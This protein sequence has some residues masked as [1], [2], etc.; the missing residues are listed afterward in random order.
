LD[1]SRKNQEFFNQ[2]DDYHS[3]VEELDTYKRTAA[4]LQGEVRG[5]VLDVG[6]GGVF[7]YDTSVADSVVAVDIAEE[8]VQKQDWAPNVSFRWGDATRLPVQDNE[9]DTCVLQLL[10]HHLAEKDYAETERRTRACIAESYRALAPGGRLVILESC[11]PKPVEVVERLTLPLFRRFLDR[12]DHPIV[13]QWHWRSLARFVR[14]AGFEQVELIEVP[15]GKLVIQLGRKWPT[16]LTPIRVYKI[17]GHKP[18][19]PAARAGAT[20]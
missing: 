10:I 17:I 7:N 4:A 13:F 9:F 16:A 8:L 19:G 11:L 20:T 6:N 15:L 18:P 3:L 1:N 14:A 5:R 2:W 12:I